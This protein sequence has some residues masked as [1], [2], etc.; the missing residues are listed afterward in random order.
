M[1][2]RTKLRS[3][4]ASSASPSVVVR[5]SLRLFFP[6]MSISFSRISILLAHFVAAIWRFAANVS[7]AF[8]TKVRR[9]GGAQFDQ[10][11][12]NSITTY[13]YTTVILGD[14]LGLFDWPS[15]SFPL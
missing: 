7:R 3:I 5:F 11:I 10:L 13:P 2:W 9:V 1:A 6:P 4:P 8:C 14:V 15:I 12:L